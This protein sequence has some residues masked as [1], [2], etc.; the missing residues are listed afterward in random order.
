MRF[1][2]RR[3]SPGLAALLAVAMQAALI[4]AQTHVHSHVHAGAGVTRR[5]AAHGRRASSPSPAARSSVR[6]ANPPFRTITATNA[7]VLVGGG[8]PV[9]ACCRRLRPWRST[10]RASACRPR[11]AS[12]KRCPAMPRS[13]SRRA[14]RRSCNSSPC[15]PPDAADRGARCRA[16]CRSHNPNSHPLAK[17]PCRPRR[18]GPIEE[19]DHAQA[20]RIHTRFCGDVPADD[21]G[22]RRGGSP[23]ARPARARP[24]HAQHRHR[25]Q[26]RLHGAGGARH[27]HRRLRARGVDRGPEGG[28]R[29]GQGAA[30]KAAG[31]VLAAGGRGLQRRRGQGRHRGR[32]PPRRR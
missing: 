16:G 5:S 1:F 11:C 13:N 10:R 30:G 27:G 26:A 19:H 15:R 17:L 9:P 7:H 12:P 31:R 28:G 24:R 20:I 2:R 21:L 4:L 32:A 6:G 25:G 23:R 29:Q 14:R 8:R 3:S 18:A 22:A